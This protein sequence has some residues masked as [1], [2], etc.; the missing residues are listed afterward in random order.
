MNRI[1]RVELVYRSGSP[2]QG[3]TL[4]GAIPTPCECPMAEG[5]PERIEPRAFRQS[6]RSGRD[7]R[8]IHAHNPESV[9]ASRKRNSLKLF[10]SD[11]GLTFFASLIA[12]REAE[13]VR[14]LVSAGVMGVSFGFAWAGTRKR[15]SAGVRVL[16]SVDL[17]ELTLTAIPAY[18]GTEVRVV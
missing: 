5:L 13:D 12:T 9:L 1:Q 7:I 18:E 2:P 8:L 15:V 4:A 10:E 14:E 17:Y 11:H 16:E 6:V 3:V